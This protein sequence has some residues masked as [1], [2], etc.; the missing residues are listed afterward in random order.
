[1]ASSSNSNPNEAIHNE[2]TTNKVDELLSS[3]KIANAVDFYNYFKNKQT[4]TPPT[5][6]TTINTINPKMTSSMSHA[7]SLY[8]AASSSYTKQSLRPNSSFQ[9]QTNTLKRNSISSYN[10]KKLSKANNNSGNMNTLD[11]YAH[12]L[13]PST[14]S[15]QL[16]TR[17]SPSPKQIRP[18][19]NNPTHTNSNKFN[20]PHHNHHNIHQYNQYVNQSPYNFRTIY[21]PTTSSTTTTTT[22]TTSQFSLYNL[23][24]NT[25]HL[26]SSIHIDTNTN[27]FNA[28]VIKDPS[29]V[30]AP[31]LSPSRPPPPVSHQIETSDSNSFLA[32]ITKSNSSSNIASSNS[33]LSTPTNNNNSNSNRAQLDLCLNNNSSSGGESQTTSL[34]SLFLNSTL[35]SYYQKYKIEKHKQEQKLKYQSSNLIKQHNNK[36]N[37]NNNNN[38]PSSQSLSNEFE[39]KKEDAINRIIRNERIKEIR[40]KMHEYELLKE[41]QSF[42]ATSTTNSAQNTPQSNNETSVETGESNETPTNDATVTNIIDDFTNSNSFPSYYR[43]VSNTFAQQ[44]HSN[45]YNNKTLRS[46]KHHQHEDDWSSSKLSAYN[47]EIANVNRKVPPLPFDEY[48]HSQDGSVIGNDDDE[49]DQDADESNEDSNESGIED[50]VNFFT[51]K[52]SNQANSHHHHQKT[53]NRNASEESLLSSI[54]SKNSSLF[55]KPGFEMYQIGGGIFNLNSSQ[56]TFQL[57]CSIIS[58][59]VKNIVNILKQVLAIF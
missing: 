11:D 3:G 44:Q 18:N 42:N 24:S 9:G 12:I 16:I 13:Q 38:N 15:S 7:D 4:S 35:T 51:P 20:K 54:F 47:L 28:Y 37:T 29:V 32:D 31:I 40:I 25:N 59:E 33:S 22:T 23:D 41:Y 56:S 49:N 5:T 50:D 6:T 17:N 57:K 27:I 45:K 52:R 26:T 2:A 8:S 1:M 39:R 30:A 19:T 36:S 46:I 48:K 58:A 34:S 53:T 21:A 10:M 14:S 43:N 55:V